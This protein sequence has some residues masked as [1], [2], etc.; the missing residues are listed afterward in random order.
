MFKIKTFVLILALLK[1]FSEKI[2]TIKFQAGMEFSKLIKSKKTY[3]LSFDSYSSI[4]ANVHLKLN[5][6]N[7]I[8]QKV[9]FSSHDPAC[10]YDPIVQSSKLDIYLEKNQLSTSKNYICVSCENDLNCE[11]NINLSQEKSGIKL[12]ESEEPILKSSY[13]ENDDDI[14]LQAKSDVTTTIY[15]LS[16]DYLSVI[17]LPSSKKKIYQIAEGSSGT[18]KV[19]S[20]NS[21]E[22]NKFGTI[23]PKNTTMYWYGNIGFSVPDP[24]KTPTQITTSFKYGTSIVS[25]TSGTETYKITVTVKNYATEYAENKIAQYIRKNVTVKT[26]QL[27]KLKAITAYPASFP[28]NYRYQSY[29]DMVIFEGGDCWASSNLI[30]YI[31]E[32]VGIKS[33][34]RYAANDGGAGGGHRNVAALVNNKIYICEAGYG[35]E[36]PNR[37]YN[38]NERNVGYSY[39]SL[40]NNEISI[41]QYDGYDEIITVP[42]KI[43]NL[44]VVGLEKVVFY[45]GTMYSGID[46]KKIT[47]PTT[48]KTIGNAV[49][50]YVKNITNITIPK[51][52]NYIAP[53]PFLGCTNLTKIIVASGNAYYSVSSGILYNKDKTEIIAYPAGKTQTTYTGLS[54][55]I[56]VY[57]HTFY[58]VKN[59]H[60]IKLP[61]GVNYI[62]EGAF[63]ESGITEIYFSGDPPEFVHHCFH[64]INVTVYYPKGNSKWKVDTYDTFSAKAVRWVQWTPPTTLALKIGDASI[65]KNNFNLYLWALGGIALL[66]LLSIVA[67]FSIKRNKNREIVDMEFP[68]DGLIA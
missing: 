12:E 27:E 20:G 22:V 13:E 4:P 35:Y 34:I 29:V 53:Y 40:G 66:I 57:N 28:Y 2:E 8:K 21:V 1:A 50:K 49:F 59:I 10:T 45:T 43:N 54:T 14:I 11:V 48:L 6:L 31:N 30:Q 3:E 46:I 16:D 64:K 18:Y 15:T 37:P 65:E 55:L 67:L 9:S 60:T 5:S 39:K 19:I 51:N 44:N 42:S 26:D 17:T 68:S 38:V 56:R 23:Y 7:N 36:S 32:K 33:H 41:Y 61:S 47:L 24:S 58:E 52:V 63:G 62:G 25:V